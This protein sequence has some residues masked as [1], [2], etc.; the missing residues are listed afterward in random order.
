MLSLCPLHFQRL[1]LPLHTLDPIHDKRDTGPVDELR[2]EE[3][4]KV[5]LLS[6]KTYAAGD[7]QIWGKKYGGRGESLVIENGLSLMS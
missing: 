1:N 5:A 4:R 7:D 3:M 2:V 6:H